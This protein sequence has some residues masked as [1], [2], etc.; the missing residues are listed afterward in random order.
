MNADGS[1]QTQLTFDSPNK[2]QVPDWSPDGQRI[3]YAAD[4]PDGSSQ[5]VIIDADGSDPVQVTADQAV[6]FGPAWSPDGAQIAFVKVESNGTR[7]VW[8]IGTDGTGAHRLAPGPASSS[9]Q[10]GSHEAIACPEF[11]SVWP[12]R[13]A[14][15]RRG[16]H[17]GMETLVDL[18]DE[19][20]GRY[21]ERPA[22]RLRGDDDATVTWSYTELMRRSR[23][24]A[25]RL[26]ALGLE[27]GDRILTWSP[28]TP[29]A[30]GGVLRR[31]ARGPRPR[32]ARPADG[33]RRDRADRGP[34]RGEAPDRRHGPGRARPARGRPRR[35]PDDRTSTTLTAEARRDLPGRLGGAGRR[36][37]APGPRRRSSSSSSRRARRARRRA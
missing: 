8:I 7:D 10:R 15:P 26:R 4:M 32:A 22:L 20:A 24:A 34:G 9:L 14:T 30:A 23:I 33:A 1:D 11:H 28:S 2:D 36:L 29:R 35:V 13:E 12:R 25:W 3:A 18:L 37:A 27:P 31:D 19:A 17:P 6:N 16:Y 21:G 5:I